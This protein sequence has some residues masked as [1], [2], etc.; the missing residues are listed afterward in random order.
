MHR[1]SPWAPAPPRGTAFDPVVGTDSGIYGADRYVFPDLLACYEYCVVASS[2]A[3][4]V[5]SEPVATPY[6]TPLHDQPRRMPDGAADPNPPRQQPR[7]EGYG[8]AQFDSQHKRLTIQL[9]LVHPRLH[10]RDEI[11]PLWIENDDLLELPHESGDVP[12]KFG[13]LPDLFLAY[14]VYLRCNPAEPAG[15]VP[16]FTPLIS[17]VPP[18]ATDREEGALTFRGRSP[19]TEM[20]I[21]PAGGGDPAL[22]V[23][24]AIGQRGGGED[25]PEVRRREVYLEIVLDVAGVQ[26][27]AD[28]FASAN[29]AGTLAEL[30]G[31]SVSRGGAYSEI[32]PL[33]PVGRMRGV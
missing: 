11:V 12:V 17:I 24:L 10:L 21:V 22:D 9:R 5:R 26:L 28:A 27:L 4:R 8:D 32:T 31:C 25:V 19:S 16:V 29:A 18:L 15:V 13:S 23:D 1:A 33:R 30:F 2:A 7:T 6:V 3:G 20:P 14:Q